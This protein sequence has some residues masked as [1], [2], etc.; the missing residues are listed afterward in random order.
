MKAAAQ[1]G[2]ERYPQS[3]P[4]LCAQARGMQPQHP[5]ELAGKGHTAQSGVCTYWTY[6]DMLY[7]QGTRAMPSSPQPQVPEHACTRRSF[8]W[9]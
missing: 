8:I 1:A 7:D 3:S 5:A 2:T 6:S 9:P 4:Q